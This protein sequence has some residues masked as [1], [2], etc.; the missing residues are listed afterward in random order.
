MWHVKPGES[1]D[2][3]IPAVPPAAVVDGMCQ[4]FRRRAAI[5]RAYLVWAKSPTEGEA[6]QLLIGLET[7]GES[8]GLM[9]ESIATITPLLAAGERASFPYDER[10]LQPG[11][12]GHA[13]R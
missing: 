13:A 3:R 7:D 8:A 2:I 10:S 1:I 12:G 11:A 9:R 6:E 5:Q 4:F